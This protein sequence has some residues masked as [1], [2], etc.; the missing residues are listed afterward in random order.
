MVD[1]KFDFYLIST[2]IYALQ[3]YIPGILSLTVILSVP[4]Q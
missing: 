1:N 2:L 3:Y 4:P